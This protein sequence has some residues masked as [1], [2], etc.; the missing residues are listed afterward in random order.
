MLFNEEFWWKDIGIYV[1]RYICVYVARYVA[2]YPEPL[3]H[4]TI[5]INSQWNKRNKSTTKSIHRICRI[6]DILFL[7]TGHQKCFQITMMQVVLRYFVCSSPFHADRKKLSSKLQ[8]VGGCWWPRQQTH[9]L[10]YV[11]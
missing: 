6:H 2:S 7:V 3:I 11:T 5:P 9:I 1:A 8:F 10:W 4:T